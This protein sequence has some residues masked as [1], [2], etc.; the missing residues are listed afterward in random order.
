MGARVRPT[1]QMFQA[2]ASAF[3]ELLE[4]HQPEII[5]VLGYELW[6]RLPKPQRENTVETDGGPIQTRVY[7]YPG[8]SARACSIKHPSSGF[9]GRHWHPRVMHL[10]R[11]V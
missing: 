4:T 2:S 11:S 5:V 10:V 6:A 9:N 1:D 7:S 3:F 8:G